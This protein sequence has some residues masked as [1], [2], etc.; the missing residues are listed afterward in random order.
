M[1]P[2]ASRMAMMFNN[3]VTIDLRFEKSEHFIET[4]KVFLFKKY[5][6]IDSQE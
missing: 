1:A 3:A 6:N 4:L 2:E 5:S